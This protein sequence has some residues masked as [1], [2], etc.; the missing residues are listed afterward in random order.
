MACRTCGLPRSSVAGCGSRAWST[1]R[2]MVNRPSTSR[3]VRP[4]LGQ[5]L[6]REQQL[7]R[8]AGAGGMPAD[9]D[10]CLAPRRHAAAESG[11][12]PARRF[13]IRCAHQ[14][15]YDVR[16]IGRA[17]MG[18]L[19]ATRGGDHTIT[20]RRGRRRV[21]RRSGVPAEQPPRRSTRDARDEIGTGRR[22]RS[23]GERRA[24][25]HSRSADGSC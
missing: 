11:G 2:P 9:R 7:H 6:G 3:E 13:Q 23:P 21:A 20:A 24:A 1:A 12:C 5:V 10:Q 19:R 16:G 17:G 22:D 18:Q 25:S 4:S 8:Y 15:T 14:A